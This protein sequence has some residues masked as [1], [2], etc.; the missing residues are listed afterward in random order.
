MDDLN[1][2]PVAY[3]CLYPQLQGP[4]TCMASLGTHTHMRIPTHRHT[5]KNKS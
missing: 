2:A 1:T 4:I 3:N 5:I